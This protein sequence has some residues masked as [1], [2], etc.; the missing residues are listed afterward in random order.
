MSAMC[1]ETSSA[2]D[3]PKKFQKTSNFEPKLDIMKC[4]EA[5]EE[6]HLTFIHLISA[7]RLCLLFKKAEETSTMLMAKI[8]I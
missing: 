2:V 6:V 1:L 3:K 8:L 7:N 5:H 4:H